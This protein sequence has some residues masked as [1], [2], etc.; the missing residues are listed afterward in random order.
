M[1][2]FKSLTCGPSKF[3]HVYKATELC[4]LLRSQTTCVA[5]LLS[6]IMGMGMC[7][8]ACHRVNVFL[9]VPCMESCHFR[10]ELIICH[11]SRDTRVVLL[12]KTPFLTF[13]SDCA[14][15]T[16]IHTLCCTI[17][18]YHVPGAN[19]MAYGTKNARATA[20]CHQIIMQHR[21]FLKPC[22]IGVKCQVK[23]L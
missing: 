10:S 8:P 3:S 12:A 11:V 13:D 15:L 4:N 7:L 22:T 16:R 2:P 19:H 18:C 17:V 5:P 6:E 20:P 9:I 23:C 1:A 21:V 14:G